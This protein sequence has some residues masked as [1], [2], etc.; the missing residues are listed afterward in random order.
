M[1]RVRARNMNGNDPEAPWEVMNETEK[2]RDGTCVCVCVCVTERER[3]LLKTRDIY[4]Q[5]IT[6]FLFPFS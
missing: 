3:L 5:Y 1:L 2:R 6:P 4:Y